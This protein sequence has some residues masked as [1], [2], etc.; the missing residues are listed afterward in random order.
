MSLPLL[1][2]FCFSSSFYFS[3]LYLISCDLF[4]FH[5]SFY[6]QFF[7]VCQVVSIQPILYSNRY[8]AISD[9]YLFL[10]HCHS[11][12]SYAIF[13]YPN[14]T[15]LFSHCFLN[16]CVFFSQ[17]LGIL[18]LDFFFIFVFHYFLFFFASFQL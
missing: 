17:T 7:I 15:S 3:C 11:S 10:F 2:K 13:L 6:G 16:F 12:P 4:L 18:S 9:S 5:F 14:L 1:V 8:F